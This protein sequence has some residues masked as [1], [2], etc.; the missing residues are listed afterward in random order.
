VLALLL[1]SAHVRVV[2]RFT[3]PPSL[4]EIVA[5]A[6]EALAWAAERLPERLAGILDGVHILV[7]E[8]PDDETVAELGLENPW[9][10][11]G[12]W[13]GEPMTQRSVAHPPTTPPAIL[14]YRLPIL[15]EWIETEVS[16]PALVR[17]VLI[18][19]IAHQVGFSDAE[20]ER[21]EREE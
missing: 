3:T 15:A 5:L 16:L 1:A 2:R 8:M 6:D 21:L 20:I 11:T 7:E 4:E 14:L 19:E 18:H 17:N 10:L 9:D 13:R 12:L